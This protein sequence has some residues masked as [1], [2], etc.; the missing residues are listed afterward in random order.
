M[1]HFKFPSATVVLRF[2]MYDMVMVL[3][4]VYQIPPCHKPCTKFETHY[5]QVGKNFF[6]LVASV[7]FQLWISPWAS[8]K[9]QLPYDHELPVPWRGPF[10]CTFATFKVERLCKQEQINNV[11]LFFVTLRCVH[12]FCLLCFSLLFKFFLLLFCL[13]DVLLMG[14]LEQPH[15]V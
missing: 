4:R 2:N 11:P 5:S 14:F 10:R 7:Y 6:Q 9:L 1:L 15:K 8:H 13:F 3:T 12:S